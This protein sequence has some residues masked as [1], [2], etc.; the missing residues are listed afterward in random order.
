MPR[1]AFVA[2]RTIDRGRVRSAPTVAGAAH[3]SSI[4]NALNLRD[5]VQAVVLAHETRMFDELPVV[6]PR[7]RDF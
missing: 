4:D 1:W 2:P 3:R 7:E 5:R 6:D